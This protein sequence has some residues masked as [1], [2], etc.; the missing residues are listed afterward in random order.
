MRY[1]SIEEI[2]NLNWLLSENN[3]TYLAETIYRL[4]TKE[5]RYIKTLID[6][7]LREE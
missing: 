7:I 1:K 3:K 2:N 4:H 5:L 6:Y